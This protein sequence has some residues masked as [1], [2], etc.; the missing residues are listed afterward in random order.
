VC[1]RPVSAALS[2]ADKQLSLLRSKVT[3]LLTLTLTS[4][5]AAAT[6]VLTNSA[7]SAPPRV[8]KVSASGTQN[9][10]AI[11][12]N[13]NRK[14]AA[15]SPNAQPARPTVKAS[16]PAESI[17]VTA[18][19]VKDKGPLA[20]TE[21]S[22]VS[23]NVTV[24]PT[25]DDPDFVPSASKKGKK[26]KKRSAIANAANP[27]HVKNCESVLRSKLRFLL[28]AETIEI[29]SLPTRHTIT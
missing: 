13:T 10:T 1:S 2:R 11:S 15:V 4:P 9:K 22:L 26:K 12:A 27:H 29:Y 21:K 16:Q 20:A 19:A 25:V 18:D 3:Y 5:V 28:D 8:D 14:P 7:N 6:K 24:E 23:G 17:A